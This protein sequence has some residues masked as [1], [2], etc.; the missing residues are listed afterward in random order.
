[1]KASGS[2]DNHHVHAISHC[3]RQGIESYCGGIGAKLLLDHRHSGTVPPFVK[4][5]NGSGTESV[6]S[7]K[8]HF[9]ARCFIMIGKF[10]DCSCLSNTVYAYNHNYI[11]FLSGRRVKRHRRLC[12]VALS[13]QFADFLTKKLVK[14]IHVYIFV[15]LYTSLYAVYDFKGCLCADIAGNKHFLE[16]I[17]EVI[18]DSATAG[19]DAS[20]LA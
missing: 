20:E 3:R 14:L 2:V 15:S 16:L 1:V 12:V 18:V 13:Q 9:I 19:K 6:G 8:H 5:L 10:A 17:K 7:T 11:R 4:L